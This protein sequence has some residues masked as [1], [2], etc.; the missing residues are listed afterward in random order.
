[1]AKSKNDSNAPTV[2]RTLAQVANNYDVNIDTVKRWRSQG[3]PGE[4]GKYPLQDISRWLRSE[5]P[6]KPHAKPVQAEDELL[7]SE[8]DSVGLER[9]RLA[10]AGLAELDLRE[11][12]GEL[13]HRESCREAFAMI[14]MRIRRMGERHGKMFGPESA[15]SVN[16]TIEE[17]EDLLVT[18][19]SSKSTVD[20][21]Q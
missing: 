12:Q 15:R 13:I 11:R 8:G 2:A 1:M 6:W 3:M 20:D 4:S 18:H 19:F 9:Y 10:K 16:A 5:G 17:C 14:A 21:E 7:V